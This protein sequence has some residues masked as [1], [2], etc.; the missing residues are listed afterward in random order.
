MFGHGD[1]E[2]A[3]YP[4]VLLELQACPLGSVDELFELLLQV[5]EH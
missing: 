1:V 5:V 2:V 3:H 4:L